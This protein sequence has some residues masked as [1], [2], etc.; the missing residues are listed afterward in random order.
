MTL[1]ETK[2]ERKQEMMIIVCIC[3][4]IGIALEHVKNQDH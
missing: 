1:A 3:A 4:A 2:W